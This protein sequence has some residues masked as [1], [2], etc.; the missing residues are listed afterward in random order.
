M[1]GF[2]EVRLFVTATDAQPAVGSNTFTN[3]LPQL[4]GDTGPDADADITPGEVYTYLRRSA[5]VEGLEVG[6]QYY[7]WVE[8]IDTVGNSSGVQLVGSHTP[9]SW[10]GNGV[11]SSVTSAQ[12][13]I[14]QGYTIDYS[15][16]LINGGSYWYPW[17]IFNY[18][19]LAGAS[20]WVSQR[21]L[22]TPQFVS[23]KLP[24]NMTVMHFRLWTHYGLRSYLL[25]DFSIQ[26]S[27]DDGA[28]WTVLGE[29]NSVTWTEIAGGELQ[30]NAFYVADFDELVYTNNMLL[31]E[32]TLASTGSYN[33]YKINVTAWMREHLG[34]SKLILIN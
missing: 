21:G 5:V 20:G 1:N 13:A 9:E 34:L 29:Y 23:I 12:N 16:F 28:T 32:G 30:S 7:F 3:I 8:A 2:Q 17:Q 26:G 19:A 15:T 6:T 18:D 31:F 25:T 11:I 10:T 27:I 33:M 4:L 24:Q 22:Y 14:D